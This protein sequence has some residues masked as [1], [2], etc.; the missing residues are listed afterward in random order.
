VRSASVSG[1]FCSFSFGAAVVG[2]AVA[3]AVAVAAAEGVVAA[4]LDADNCRFDAV[5]CDEFSVNASEAGAVVDEA[6]V[7]AVVNAAVAFP[8]DCSAFAFTN[9]AEDVFWIGLEEPGRGDSDDAPSDVEEEDGASPCSSVV[10]GILRG[11]CP[12]GCSSDENDA[13][14]FVFGRLSFREE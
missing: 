1:S 9:N 5:G 3:M 10:R 2:A 8:E 14:L 4:A 11:G 13:E 7:N 12:S 6:V